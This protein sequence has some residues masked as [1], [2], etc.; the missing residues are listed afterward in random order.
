MTPAQDLVSSV[1]SQESFTS[2]ASSTRFKL[3]R[4]ERQLK[5]PYRKGTLRQAEPRALPKTDR[6]SCSLAGD[7]RYERHPIASFPVRLLRYWKQF[8]QLCRQATPKQ[9]LGERSSTAHQR[10]GPPCGKR[11]VAGVHTLSRLENVF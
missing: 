7:I 9:P 3:T 2:I 1:Q 5:V 6:I 4:A 8:L 10:E 11:D